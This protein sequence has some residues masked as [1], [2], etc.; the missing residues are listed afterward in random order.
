MYPLK[1]YTASYLPM[2]TR[3]YTV[4]AEAANGL[5]GRGWVVRQE[6][7]NKQQANRGGPVQQTGHQVG[8]E[9]VGIEDGENPF[10]TAESDEK[11][12]SIGRECVRVRVF[13]HK[14]YGGGK[15]DEK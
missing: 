15:G 14:G 11:D 12:I 13:L 4:P 3:R 1:T 9:P 7:Q 6:G 5:G 2:F 8:R 10:E